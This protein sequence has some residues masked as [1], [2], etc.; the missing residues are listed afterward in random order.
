M[1]GNISRI[2]TKNKII[3]LLLTVFSVYGFL[4]KIVFLQPSS[5]MNDKNAMGLIQINVSD[6]D[7]RA[8]KLIASFCG[9]SIKDFVLESIRCRINTDPLI[10]GFLNSNEIDLDLV[11]DWEE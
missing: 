9:I 11:K 6:Q 4:L 5:K 8:I 2:L 3:F 1:F 7:K 10:Q